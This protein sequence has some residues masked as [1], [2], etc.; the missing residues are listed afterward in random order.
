[1][2]TQDHGGAILR[3]LTGPS[4]SKGLMVEMTTLLERQAGTRPLA[5]AHRAGNH[6]DSLRSAEEAGVDLV[7]ADIWFYRKRLEVRHLKT[8]GPLTL[9][10]DRWELRSAAGPRLLLANLLQAASPTTT[11]ML[12]LKGR[13]RQLATAVADA[14]TQSLPGRPLVIC[15]RHWPLLD[16]FAGQALV[17]AVHS[18]GNGRQFAA[19]LPRLAGHA[20]PAVSVHERLLT[21]ATVAAVKERGARIIT[22]P[23]NTA[24][25]VNELTALGVD[26]VISDDLALL[27][28]IVTAAP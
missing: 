3:N 14:C 26:G 10:W 5:I 19:V 2:A 12:D 22:W 1:M 25:R 6:L 9:L 15:A 18:V 28:Q 4:A 13:D 20:H 17:T 16:A 11:L 21:P 7:E 24:A 27:H 8:L 23:I